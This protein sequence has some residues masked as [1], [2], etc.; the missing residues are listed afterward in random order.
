MM[1]SL[2]F[3][4]LFVPALCVADPQTVRVTWE[5]VTTRTDGSALDNLGGYTLLW[6]DSE[7]AS[8]LVDLDADETTRDIEIDASGVVSLRMSAYDSN[9]V[10]SELSEPLTLNLTPPAAPSLKSII[11]VKV[12]VEVSQ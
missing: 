4:L 3:A 12:T 6:E 2:M 5:E 7:G 8:G 10:M 9:N 1:R 11:V